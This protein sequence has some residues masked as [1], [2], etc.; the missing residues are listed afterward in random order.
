MIRGKKPKPRRS[1]S[2]RP[3]EQVCPSCGRFLERSHILWRKELIFVSGAES[4]VSWVYRCPEPTCITRQV[5][6]SSQE[7]E[8][9]HLRYRRYSREVII[10]LGYRRFWH[11]QTIYELHEWFT[12]GLGLAITPRQISNVL[13]DFLALLRAGQAQKLRCILPKQSELLISIDGM[14]PEKGND[15]LYIVREVQCGQTLLAETLTDNSATMLSRRLLEPLKVLATD[16]GLSWLGVVSDAQESIR[17]AVAQSLPG[18]P[19][20]VCQSHCL[21]GA[22]K[23][24]FEADRNLKKRLKAAFRRQLSQLQKQLGKLA[25]HD[26]YRP[27]LTDYADAMQS[28]L[29]E[30]GLAPFDLGGVNVYTALEAIAHSLHRCQKKGPIHSYSDC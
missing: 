18:V 10:K 16:L 23:L 12:E 7:A 14:Q 5:Q 8:R 29:L 19:H 26:R 21:R 1:R 4:V 2:Y 22:G 9:L 6:Y 25:E 27:V 24:T 17:L 30:G 3:E 20:Q 28:T 13:G 15:C 11:Y